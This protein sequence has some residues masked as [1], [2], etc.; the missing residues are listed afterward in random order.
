MDR[1]ETIKAI[2]TALKNRSGKPWSVKCGRGTAGG[3][4]HIS[5]PPKR[6]GC[7]ELHAYNGTEFC[8][9][10]GVEQYGPI[11]QGDRSGVCSKHVCDA[12]P[13]GCYRNYI[14]PSD[15]AELAELLG[16]DTVHMQGVDIPAGSD[17]YREYVARA[18]GLEPVVI[19][20]PYWD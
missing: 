7:A 5:V 17:Y 18:A 6:L 12:G 2:R 1:N 9:D 10:C 11:I 19:G 15:R 4:L 20:S 14:T 3:W 8:V 16:L 13:R